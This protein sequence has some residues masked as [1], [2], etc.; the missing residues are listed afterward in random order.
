MADTSG[1]PRTGLSVLIVDD[2]RDSAEMLQVLL[3]M[4]GHTVSVAH[5]GRAAIDCMGETRPHVVLLDIG[6][7]DMTGYDVAREIR[8]CHADPVRLIALTGWGQEDGGQQAA[9]AG[10][11]QYLTKPA[12]PAVL[13]RILNEVA[14]SVAR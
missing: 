1:V 12:D 9:D 4:L 8:A 14:S 11:D 3:G 2:N 7:P 13:E 6:L 5:T 10:I